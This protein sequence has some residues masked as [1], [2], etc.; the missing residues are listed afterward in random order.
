[1]AT[2]A[3]MQLLS[4]LLSWSSIVTW[5]T[6]LQLL[7]RGLL[8]KIWPLDFMLIHPLG[9]WYSASH[10]SM[11]RPLI[12]LLWRNVRG[13]RPRNLAM[14]FI[15]TYGVLPLLPHSEDTI[16]LSHLRMIVHDSLTYTSFIVRVKPWKPISTTK[17]KSRLSIRHPLRL[18]T[19]IEAANILGRSLLCTSRSKAHNKSLQCMILPNIMALQSA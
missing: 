9:R 15:P 1:M 3:C 17:P 12:S 2:T 13:S 16:I 6:F 18:C 7:L 14:R 8:R 10:A 4:P 19:Q 5:A 11:Q